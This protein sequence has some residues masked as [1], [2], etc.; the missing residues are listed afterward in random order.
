MYEI[1]YLVIKKYI[2]LFCECYNFSEVGQSM[3][4]RILG[5]QILLEPQTHYEYNE[6]K[7]LKNLSVRIVKEAHCLA[8]HSTLLVRSRA[9][10]SGE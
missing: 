7:S 8:I 6:I 9:K 10:A 5:K 2:R 3:R 4:L 1:A